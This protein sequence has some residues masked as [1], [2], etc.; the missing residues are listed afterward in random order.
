MSTQVV[1]V[2][3]D[4]IRPADEDLRRWMERENNVYIGRERV[5]FVK[6]GEKKER[7]P[8]RASKWAN[9]FKIGSKYTRET[10]LVEY[11]HYIQQKIN[12][13]PITYDLKELVGKNLGCWCHPEPCHGD[14]LI[15]LLE[16]LD[17]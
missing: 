5:V 4:D 12:A 1:C 8:K 13:D 14:I 16:N 2:K 6:N 9:P 3:V 10:C 7:W 15:K 11:E 17:S